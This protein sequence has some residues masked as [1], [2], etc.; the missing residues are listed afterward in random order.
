MKLGL[1]NMF[2]MLPPMLALNATPVPH[3]PLFASMATTPAQ[4]VP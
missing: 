4:R 1:Y 3:I 2:L